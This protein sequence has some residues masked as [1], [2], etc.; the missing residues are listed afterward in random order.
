MIRYALRCARGP[1]PTKSAAD[2][3]RFVEQCTLLTELGA[4]VAS[5]R[6][7]A[8]GV[9]PIIEDHLVIEHQRSSRSDD[10]KEHGEILYN[11]EVGS[12]ATG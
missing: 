1:Y 5:H 10:V 7:D 8:A 2:N 12:K 11:I 3:R 9:A 4:V 6:G